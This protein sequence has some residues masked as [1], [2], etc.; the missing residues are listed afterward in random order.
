MSWIVEM[1]RNFKKRKGK[2]F[3]QFFFGREVIKRNRER[4][5]Q[6]YQNRVDRLQERYQSTKDH[7]EQ[8]FLAQ[9]MG[10]LRKEIKQMKG[11]DVTE[12][13]DAVQHNRL[14]E[15]YETLKKRRRKKLQKE[16]KEYKADVRTDVEYAIN[17]LVGLSILSKKDNVREKQK[18]SLKS[19]ISYFKETNYDFSFIKLVLGSLMLYDSDWNE[20]RNNDQVDFP[21]F[22]TNGPAILGKLY[23]YYSEIN[24]SNLDRDI[25]LA[26]PELGLQYGDEHL[27]RGKSF[28]DLFLFFQKKELI[29]K[30][31]LK[32]AETISGTGK[33]LNRFSFKNVDGTL[34]SKG[35]QENI[36]TK[37]AEVSDATFDLCLKGY[38]KSKE[39]LQAGDIF[40][41]TVTK[42][43]IKDGK[44]IYFEVP[45][46]AIHVKKDETTGEEYIN[47][48]EVHG[49]GENQGINPQFLEI[50]REF[51]TQKKVV[52]GPNGE[53]QE[54]YRFSNAQEFEMK[55]ADT[56]MYHQVKDKIENMKKLAESGVK[57]ESGDENDLTAKELKFLYQIYRRVIGFELASEGGLAGKVDELYKIRLKILHPTT[58]NDNNSY[59]ITRGEQVA[60]ANVQ[61]KKD[62]ADMFQ[63]PEA[64]VMKTAPIAHSFVGVS[65]YWNSVNHLGLG[66]LDGGLLLGY[67][68][69]KNGQHEQKFSNSLKVVRGVCELGGCIDLQNLREITGELKLNLINV[70]KFDHLKKIGG[71]TLTD[72]DRHGI[73][74]GM[75]VKFPNSSDPRLA[76][77]Y[78]N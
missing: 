14:N 20:R 59:P 72:E 39:Y 4:R 25:S 71:I 66:L 58:F 65:K 77:V 45:E 75:F 24:A 49:N 1:A 50:A 63:I 31:L 28:K 42:K 32:S 73:K 47:P 33:W 57:I 53:S 60:V 78:M 27:I 3:R 22:P 52:V 23:T 29:S 64:A 44:E 55:F 54:V 17:Y 46:I 21:T 6:S 38:T 56:K 41:Y 19:W 37:L 15:T 74:N 2:N 68:Q 8:N 26:L 48:N 9:Q 40:I 62:L 34:K 36:T 10:P 69:N 13:D 43:V 70:E 11:G 16:G 7:G 30:A 12:A 18:K 35:E 5:L 76:Y 61:R 51:V 67:F